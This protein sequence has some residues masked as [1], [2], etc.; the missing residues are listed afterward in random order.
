MSLH[1]LIGKQCL[2]GKNLIKQGR[3]KNDEIIH[4]HETGIKCLEFR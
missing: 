2:L 3:R 4:I 1:Q